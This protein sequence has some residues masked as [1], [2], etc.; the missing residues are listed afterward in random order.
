MKNFTR[1][2]TLLLAVLLVFNVAAS[3]SQ[4]TDIS[5]G[6][7]G[8]SY[9]EAIDVLSSMGIFVGDSEG[10][11]RPNDYITRAE[12]VAIVNR[13]TGLSSTVSATGYIPYYTDVKASDWFAADVTVAT[14]M[15]IIAGDGDGTFRPNDYV[16]YE[17]MVKMLV[18]A[19]NYSDNFVGKIGGFPTGYLVLASNLGITSG[20]NETSGNFAARKIVARLT[21]Q[22]LTAPMFS[23]TSYSSDGSAI[24]TE[25]ETKILLE[26][27]LNM[28]KLEGYVSANHITSLN[29]AS[30]NCDEGQVAF[31]ITAVKDGEDVPGMG[32]GD[33]VI[34]NTGSSDIAD[35]L[36][37]S[38]TVYIGYDYY[39][40]YYVKSYVFSARKANK[41]SIEDTND[42]CVPADRYP[43]VLGT[44]SG[45]YISVYDEETDSSNT[46]YYLDRNAVFVVNGKFYG[47]ANSIN[48]NTKI[49]GI[50][51]GDIGYIY[52]PNQGNVTLLDRNGDKKY[53]VVNVTAYETFV[54][55]EVYS[56]YLKIATKNSA[57][58]TL[59]NKNNYSYRI[60]YNNREINSSELKEWDV[61]SV[62]RSLDNKSIDIIVSRD[63]TTGSVTSMYRAP[64]IYDSEYY[65]NGSPYRVASMSD[66][67]ISNMDRVE[68]GTYGD[69]YFDVFGNIAYF[70]ITS[71]ASNSSYAFISGIEQV[72]RMGRTVYN[73]QLLLPSGGTVVYEIAS[74]VNVTDYS[75][76]SVASTKS[77]AEVFT[78]V[79]ALNGNSSTWT[80]TSD[81][82]LGTNTKRYG[83]RIVRYAVNS[84]GKL[85]TL[86]VANSNAYSNGGD[87]LSVTTGMGVEY[88]KTNL[89]V[90]QYGITKNTIVF[91]L[92]IKTNSTEDDF[93][94]ANSNTLSDRATYNVAYITPDDYYDVE[95]LVITNSAVTVGD[96][97]N[98]AVVKKVQAAVD[99]DGYP[100]ARLTFMQN[101][102]LYTYD[103]TA[104]LGLD[105]NDFKAGDVFEYALNSKGRIE[106][107]AFSTADNYV[108]SYNNIPSAYQ[109]GLIK[110]NISSSYANAQYVFGVVTHKDGG[111]RI[112]QLAT[113]YGGQSTSRHR[114]PS[115]ANIT[116]VDL[117]KSVSSENRVVNG[118]Y[119][120]IQ[121]TKVINGAID[122]DLDYTAL[123]KY[124]KDEVTDVV[125]F[126]GYNKVVM[127][128]VIG[129][130][131]NWQYQARYATA[132]A[133]FEVA[134]DNY[135][136]KVA[137][138]NRAQSEY[139]DALAARDTAQEN[140]DTILAQEAEDESNSAQHREQ[141]L[142]NARQ[143]VTVAEEALETAREQ[144]AGYEEDLL[145]AEGEYNTALDE[146]TEAA[147]IK[148]EKKTAFENKK[149]EFEAKKEV[150]QEKLEAKENAE[151]ALENLPAD[152]TPEERE[153]AQEAV[154][155]AT[156]EY[157]TAVAEENQVKEE[158]ETAEE[159][160][161][162]TEATA[163][164]KKSIMETKLGDYTTLQGKRAEFEGNVTEAEENLQAKKDVV[165]ALE[166]EPEL[167][168]NG[169]ESPEVTAARATLANAQ[170]VLD[171]KGE[172]LETAENEKNEAYET[173]NEK[174]AVVEEIEQYL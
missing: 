154:E 102:G 159:E 126:K 53:D 134:E 99:E 173:L 152:A 148:N 101:S 118:V 132:R 60:T 117:T 4:Y 83:N 141:A 71:R 94:I 38:M 166:N 32:V 29:S 76:S 24:Y 91:M 77:A 168:E 172:A 110:T 108:L 169:E 119:G 129:N 70:D 26:Q 127:G 74:R 155:N 52:A 171:E 27:K 51:G 95:V 5:S 103:T 10:T 16:L 14:Q 106:K 125:I 116:I 23:L 20:I 122:S 48:T 69:V 139:N 174:K 61:I 57:T 115:S 18:A 90:G 170:S 162:E 15:N 56:N 130:I 33:T 66:Y 8:S 167:T 2:F 43:S 28:R 63:R 21:Y 100:V 86:D 54:V 9:E 120:D 41:V 161:E 25:D 144:L 37:S 88:N 65:I 11:F 39:D 142:S 34:L 109:S 135:N 140:L 87:Y 13:I 79:N 111:T 49:P 124:S 145:A 128:G 42:I 47:Y 158:M 80:Y 19:L 67:T 64:S 40:D 164:E 96:S 160:Y 157:E 55:D 131:F 73:I 3:A 163:G 84:Q 104:D 143:E 133:E 45:M 113:E 123:I 44:S 46:E 36:G 138:Y 151:E 149:T 85:S 78:L 97:S 62:A 17:E 6:N 72:T 59:N 107:V 7:L 105:A 81:D 58:I 31:T 114:I 35:Y 12:A 1:I 121:V 82:A 112:I 98:L 156:E 153:L 89:T 147:G 30:T 22:T 136:E 146:Y 93:T 75:V 137:N 92:P 68:A 50:S 165:T 150:T